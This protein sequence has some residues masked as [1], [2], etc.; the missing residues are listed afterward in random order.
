MQVWIYRRWHRSIHETKNYFGGKALVMGLVPI[1][2]FVLERVLGTGR[3]E[4][5][6]IILILLSS[7][8]VVGVGVFVW[9]FAARVPALLRLENER[10]QRAEE[11]LA[12]HTTEEKTALVVLAEGGGMTEGQLT[13]RLKDRGFSPSSDI[14]N[15][16]SGKTNFLARDPTTGKWSI[17]P[18]FK[19]LLLKLLPEQLRKG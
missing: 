18:A 2:Y 7:Y 6:K 8:A 1:I 4:Q 9:E 5:L 17:E 12:K 16:I 11:S 14:L 10:R 15:T 3:P 19:E 13:E